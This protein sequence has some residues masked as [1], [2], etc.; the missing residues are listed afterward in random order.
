MNAVARTLPRLA[1]R[2]VVT[3]G[4]AAAPWA[5]FAIRDLS[6]IFDGAAIVLPLLLGGMLGAALVGALAT[7]SAEGALVVGS[8]LLFSLAAIAGPWVPQ[9]GAAP[10]EP[11]RVVSA[12]LGEATEPFSAV[13]DVIAQKPDVV[14]VPEVDY[15][16][17][18]LFTSHFNDSFMFERST[19]V[20]IYSRYPVSVSEIP[21]ARL[22]RH[23]FRAEIAAPSGTFVVY[24]LHLP[25]PWFNDEGARYVSLGGQRDF[26]EALAA[27]A[28][29]E[30]YP[31]VIAGDLNLTDRA[32][33]YRTLA[34]NLRDAVLTGGGGPTSTRFE[35]RPLLLRIDH[36]F[37]TRNWCASSG[38][39]FDAATADH[40][41][42]L[43]DV[44]P[45]E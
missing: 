18:L 4:L 42:V 25:K 36:I 31:V 32:A 3:L 5:W 7:R 12:N 30:P 28:A 24:A 38:G 13:E 6:P 22:H 16:L 15:V 39:R 23:G 40:R 2:E 44:G 34:S 29:R 35:W 19:N 33:G 43:A 14:I 21:D 17:D 27:A 10:V 1:V 26:T 8:W 37:V 45:C 41:A 20:G 11:L 9:A